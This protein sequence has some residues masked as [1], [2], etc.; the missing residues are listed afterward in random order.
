MDF[1]LNDRVFS[2]SIGRNGVV[3]KV[4]NR[5]NLMYPLWVAFNNKSTD[6]EFYTLDGRRS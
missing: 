6:F 4:D 3:T 1:K 5:P 2:K